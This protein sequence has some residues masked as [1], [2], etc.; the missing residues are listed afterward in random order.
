[1]KCPIEALIVNEDEEEDELIC[2][3]VVLGGTFDR[4]HAGH[5]I[6][7]SEA[8][9]RCRSRL[10]IG[11]TDGPMLASKTLS[12]LIQPCE[13]RIS[14][15]KAYLKTSNPELEVNAVPITDPYGPSIEMESLGLIVGSEETAKGCAKVNEKRKE[16]GLSQLAVKLVKCVQD[17]NRED[18]RVEEAKVS[19]SSERKRLLGT[20]LEHPLTIWKPSENVPYVVG[21][22]GSSAS[23]KSSVG[24]HLAA[25]GAGVVDCDK[26]GHLAYSPGSE[27]LKKVA[28]AFGDK[29]IGNDGAVDRRILGQLVF[30]NKEN[31][32]KLE[33]IV[34][35][36]I[37]KA[38][39]WKIHQLFKEEGKTVI[40][41]DAAVLLRA[42]WHKELCHEVWGCVIPRDEAVK[43]ICE[44]DGKSEK[45]ALKRLE[46]G[47]SNE[48]VVKASSVIFCTQWSVEYTKKQVSKAWTVL[49]E[50]MK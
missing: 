48:E 29:V 49:Q 45:E 28:A 7:L 9:T 15:L 42:G 25:I 31:Q 27:C 20:R 21:L 50:A 3:E 36:E 18:E 2:D 14:L 5:K 24:R 12:E 37:L 4:L 8:A 46:S 33:S 26:L 13:E 32:A 43:R 1:L 30:G 23:G 34:W 10:T 38:T 47:L 44:R 16:R 22:T 35:P 19:S 17:S 40:I 41:V 11:V 39:K 6:L